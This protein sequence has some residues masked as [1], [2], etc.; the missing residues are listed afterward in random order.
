MMNFRF[1][2]FSVLAIVFF[3]TL[4]LHAPV[5]VFGAKINFTLSLMVAMAFFVQNFFHYAVFL[6]IAG[7]WL[8]FWPGFN[9]E[10]FSLSVVL[11]L[12]FWIRTRLIFPGGFTAALLG[13]F[14]TLAFYVLVD[15]VFVYDRASLA[16]L[17]GVL[18]SAMSFVF[19]EAI[20]FFHEKKA[21]SAI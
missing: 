14:S 4:Q 19:F 10:V 6:L 12:A 15:P 21:R 17:E 20:N 3:A 1:V 13:F 18:N 7:F 16:L 5:S 11:S 2:F 8:R 9:R